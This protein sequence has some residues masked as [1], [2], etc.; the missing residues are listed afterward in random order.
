MERALSDAGYTV[1]RETFLA[2]GMACHDLVVERA[3][4]SLPNEVVVIGAHYDGVLDKPAADDNA[5]GAAGLIELARAFAH[6]TTA[7]TLRFVAFTNEEPHHFQTRTMGSL[8]YAGRVR[9]RG[10]DVVA[11]LSV[12][13]IGFYNTRPGSQQ[14]PPPLSFFYPDRGDFIAFVGRDEEVSLVRH[15]VET[16]RAHTHFPSEGVALPERMPGVGWSD[17]WS[18]WRAGYPAVMVTDTAFNRNPNYHTH[19]D[20]ADTLDYDRMARV[21]SGIVPVVRDLANAPRSS[22]RT[23]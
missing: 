7:R 20:T 5:S 21:V 18:F 6:E 12:E 10:D 15:V 23:R 9:A 3:G 13:M 4:P 14:Y 1:T 19:H 22:L 17:H 2:D 11:M 8:V 16:F